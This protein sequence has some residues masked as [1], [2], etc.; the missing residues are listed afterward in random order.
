MSIP[1]S[2][3]TS[4]LKTSVK[5]PAANSYG[6]PYLTR[7]ANLNTQQAAPPYLSAFRSLQT[8]YGVAPAG[9]SVKQTRAIT[10]GYPTGPAN[11]PKDSTRRRSFCSRSTSL[12]PQG[13]TV[14]PLTNSNVIHL[15]RTIGNAA[16]QRLLANN[17]M[18][19]PS[20][21]SNTSIQRLM[22]VS[23]FKGKSRGILWGA[24]TGKRDEVKKGRGG[25]NRP[26][27]PFPLFHM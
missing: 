23:Q 5:L 1:Y 22:S 7:S 12:A 19:R 4:Y 18:M 20:T 26:C 21:G 27:H 3:T 25:K 14:V 6:N 17:Q 11:V 24:F 2:S 10:G 16:V 9:V 15:Q 13:G 8:P